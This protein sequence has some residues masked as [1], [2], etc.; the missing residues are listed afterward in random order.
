MADLRFYLRDRVNDPDG[1]APWQWHCLA[2]SASDLAPGALARCPAAVVAQ[3]ESRTAYRRQTG[4][5]DSERFT[6]EEIGDGPR[7]A[8]SRPPGA[9]CIPGSPL[10]M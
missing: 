3:T 9:V 6:V 5:L 1:P 10:Q 4:T 2:S 8:G 7:R